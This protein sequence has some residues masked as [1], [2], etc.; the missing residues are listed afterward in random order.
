MGETPADQTGA[1]E[2]DERTVRVEVNPR[3]RDLGSW[4]DEARAKVAADVV[5]PSAAVNVKS[6]AFFSSKS[7]NFFVSLV[8]RSAITLPVATS[9]SRVAGGVS[10]V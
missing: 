3:G 1:P 2:R 8:A 6:S 7:A 4:V 5:L 9:T 10:C